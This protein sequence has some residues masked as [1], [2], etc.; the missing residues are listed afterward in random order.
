M[1]STCQSQ[2][3]FKFETS[4]AAGDVILQKRSTEDVI[5]KRRARDGSIQEYLEESSKD[6]A[7]MLKQ[8]DEIKDFEIRIVSNV[9]K[10]DVALGLVERRE[11]D[12]E[13]DLDD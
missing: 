12:L 2:G 1:F 9:L 11:E 5:C 7:E 3:K 13:S 4:G 6:V 8:H 10:Q